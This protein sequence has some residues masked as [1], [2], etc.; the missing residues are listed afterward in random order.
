MV[1]TVF[2][3]MTPVCWGRE[4]VSRR[5]LV[6]ARIPRSIPRELSCGKEFVILKKSCH[7]ERSEGPASGARPRPDA[8]GIRN[9]SQGSPSASPR[10]DG[11]LAGPPIAVSCA[12]R[13]KA[14]LPSLR[15]KSRTH[16]RNAVRSQCALTASRS[17]AVS[18]GFFAHPT[19]DM[20]GDQPASACAWS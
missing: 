16:R 6:A 20:F 12:S 14:R 11:T 3:I 5:R 19:K 7:H 9:S 10:A 15:G 17:M 4:S 18:V 1:G 2:H 8:L 13:Q